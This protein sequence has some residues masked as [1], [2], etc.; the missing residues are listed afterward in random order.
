MKSRPSAQYIQGWLRSR[1]E[2]EGQ[3]QAAWRTDPKRSGA[4]GAFGDIG[5][6]AYNLGRYMTG[7]LPE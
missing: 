6:H 1:L 4:A 5:T 3:K 2:S 7:L